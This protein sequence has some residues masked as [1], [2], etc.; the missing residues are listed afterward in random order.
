MLNKKIVIA[1]LIILLS[2]FI[3]FSKIKVS[4]LFTWGVN[5][6]N[7]E[8]E[9]PDEYSVGFEFEFLKNTTFEFSYFY[10]P[11]YFNRFQNDY[12]HGVNLLVGY[13]V[14]LTKKA[15]AFAKAGGV[16]HYSTYEDPIEKIFNVP[17]FYIYKGWY[18]GLK[19]GFKYKVIDNK[20]NLLCGIRYVVDIA[21]FVIFTGV[22][23][24]L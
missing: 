17:V 16:Y 10:S 13:E 3:L 5:V 20:I 2:N 14:N 1:V 18:L 9:L 8:Y 22:E 15:R 24:K 19:A 6:D 4:T 11:D 7:Y 12:C 23:F 21:D